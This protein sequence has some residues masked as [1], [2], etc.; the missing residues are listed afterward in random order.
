MIK[1]YIFYFITLLALAGPTKP[2]ILKNPAYDCSRNS[3]IL[4]FYSIEPLNDIVRKTNYKIGTYA[5]EYKKLIEQFDTSSTEQIFKTDTI[6]ILHSGS[7]RGKG[8]SIRF[9]DSLLDSLQQKVLMQKEGVDE[10]IKHLLGVQ[11]KALPLHYY[12]STGYFSQ[13]DASLIT[14]LHDGYS[15][16]KRIVKLSEYLIIVTLKQKETKTPFTLTLDLT[17]FCIP[18]IEGST[19]YALHAII[20]SNKEHMTAI[21]QWN[22]QWYFSSDWPRPIRKELSPDEMSDFA[23]KGIMSQDSDWNKD[24]V[25]D[26]FIYK[27]E[28]PVEKSLELLAESLALLA[29]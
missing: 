10:R 20:A 16:G 15:Q 14:C 22:N 5:A 17:P 6:C 19:Q 9:S 11:T 13:P 7:E 26:V 29:Q 8:D 3:I 21:T 1:K 23:Q 28:I 2:P 25:P 27:R 12:F 4:A 24:L 18:N